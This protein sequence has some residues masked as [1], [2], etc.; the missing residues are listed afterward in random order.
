[1]NFNTLHFQFAVILRDFPA[2]FSKKNPGAKAG[3]Y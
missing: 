3:I 1:M 2:Y